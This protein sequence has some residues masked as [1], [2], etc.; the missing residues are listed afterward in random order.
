MSVDS[1][2][3]FPRLQLLI[4][5][6]LPMTRGLP[7]PPANSVEGVLE[8]AGVHSVNSGNGAMYTVHRL[9]S[10]G[11]QQDFWK[12]PTIKGEPGFNIV[13]TM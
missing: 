6:S 13:R 7:P 12:H 1:L 9:N 8:A 5:R 3:A 10:N 2:Q 11:R 4:T